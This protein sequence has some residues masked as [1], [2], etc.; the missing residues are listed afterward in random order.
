MRRILVTMFIIATIAVACDKNKFQTKPT[1]TL[2]AMNGDIIPAGASLILDFE[3]T[4]KEGDV[5]DS[6][7]VFK[8]RINKVKTATVRD[9]FALPV[10]EF[11]K[12][13][14][15][16]VQV[17]LDHSFYLVSAIQPPKDQATGKFHDDTL[18]LRFVLRDRAGNA[19][20]TTSVGPIIVLRN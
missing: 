12:N 19:S 6:I 18:M 16:E 14:K 1:L 5:S 3:F 2:K 4:D 17:T 10:P 7:F 9:N 15:G 20:D 13:T 8:T 11:P